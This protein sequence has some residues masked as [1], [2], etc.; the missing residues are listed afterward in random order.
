ML[1]FD[2]MTGRVWKYAVNSVVPA[3]TVCAIVDMEMRV[4]FYLCQD[5]GQADYSNNVYVAV[6]E[7]SSL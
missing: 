3:L 4:T 2:A 7:S 5:L 6:A 1:T